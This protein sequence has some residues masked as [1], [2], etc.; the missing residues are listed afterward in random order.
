MMKIRIIATD[1]I[2]AGG[3]WRIT[4]QSECGRL[5]VTRT[6]EPE[7]GWIEIKLPEATQLENPTL[8]KS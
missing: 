4:A 3:F 5:W 2:G 8:R 6:N 1:W 7:K